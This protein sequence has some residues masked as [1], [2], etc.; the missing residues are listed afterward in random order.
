MRRRP[1]PDWSY[2]S[3]FKPLLFRLSGR[4]AR[5]LTLQ[6]IGG[7][8]RIPGGTFVIR[9]MGHMELSPLLAG[10][11]AG[12][13]IACPV[14]LSGGLDP[15]GTAHKALA[16]FGLGFIELGP[17]TVRAVDSHASIIRMADEE[18][19]VY[20]DGYVN[21][22]ADAIVARLRKGTGHR[23]PHFVRLRPMPGSSPR[24]ALEEQRELLL[25]LAPYA[26]GFTLD[27]L[28]EGWPAAMALAYLAE[29]RQLAHTAAPGKPVLL[30]VPQLT[31]LGE[32]REIVDT[33]R[34]FSGV[35]L[36]DAQ[37]EP[38]TRRERVGGGAAVLS[39][40]LSMVCALREA[41]GERSTIVAAGGVHQ[42]QDAL[43]LLEA[44]ANC[45]M[46]HSGLV[47]AGPGLPKRI[48]EAILYDR[49]TSSFESI[50][51]T[52]SPNHGLLLSHHIANGD[53]PSIPATASKQG[54][55]QTYPPSWKMSS[56]PP[57]PSFWSN[58]GW[59][60]LLG[61]GM[62]IGGVL[63][64][65]IAATTVV[66]PYD[67]DFLGM[68]RR[69]IIRFNAHLLHFMSHDR[70]TL[71]GTM[72]SIGIFYYQLA[73]HGL[74]YGLHWARTAVISSCVVGFS[75]FFLYLGYGYFDPLHAIAAAILLPMLLLTLRGLKDVPSRKPPGLHNDH[76][77]L[78][79]QW[80]QCCLVVLGFG[81]G[82]GGLTISIVGITGVFVPS[83][84]VYLGLTTSELSAWSDAI[85][86]LIAH[87]R[88]GFGGALFCLAVAITASALWGI[89][90]GEGWLWWTFLWG[91]IPG[92]VAGLFVHMH[93][94]YTDFVHLLPV[95]IA[96]LLYIAGLYLTYPFLNG[97]QVRM[98]LPSMKV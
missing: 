97:R 94:G 16:Q 47:Y 5:D 20:P 29:V 74:R 79:A 95:Y 62:I 49:I 81:L 89:N 90:Q 32:L 69:A 1:M 36:G 61:L 35:V 86:P 25:A 41:L 17:V 63:A 51:A 2:H 13:P 8:S 46:L 52:P 54:E 31:P 67:E 3:I 84:L 70:I 68:S 34:S 26:A 76:V 44:G 43:A 9:T 72:I 42:P 22:G 21:D 58:W 39:A 33:A 75:S 10:E 23:L 50:D 65:L 14:G 73:H 28:A 96:A 53:Q 71:A 24:E 40:Q 88:A 57:T 7:L 37:R 4:T 78:R 38:G 27:G 59:M 93:I 64:W 82:I 98:D 48:N 11:L 60:S 6:A 83:D 12:V 80:G 19:I 92:F 18:A 30:Y 87:D 56:F 45:V 91:G 66:L 85:I 15:H 77:W 55:E